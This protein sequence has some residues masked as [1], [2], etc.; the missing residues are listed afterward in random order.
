MTTVSGIETGPH[1]HGI[2]P[3]VPHK[4]RLEMQIRD[5][6]EGRNGLEAGSYAHQ[7]DPP[8]AD[9]QTEAE[10]SLLYRQGSVWHL[11]DAR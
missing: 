4:H 8:A 11:R 3:F 10:R 5:Y 1:I 6:V 9:P 7:P 2:D